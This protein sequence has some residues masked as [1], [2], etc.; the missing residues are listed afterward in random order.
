MNG[1]GEMSC[2]HTMNYRNYLMERVLSKTLYE[3]AAV[4]EDVSTGQRVDL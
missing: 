4:N 3:N 1:R 2:S